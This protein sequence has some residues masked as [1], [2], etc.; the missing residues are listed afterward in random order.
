MRISITL[1][2]YDHGIIRQ[3]LDVV[4]CVVR[5]HQAPKHVSELQ[6]A[7]VFLD[8]FMDRFHHAK[9]EMFLFP[10][11]AEECPKVA[12]LLER[13]KEEHVTARRLLRSALKA[14]EEGDVERMEQEVRA[15]VDHMT[16]HIS[17]EEN[18][19]FP[20]VENTL[21]LETDAKLHA[22]YERFMVEK[23]GKSYYEVSEEFANDLQDRLLGPGYFTGIC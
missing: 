6:E 4:G 9:E 7:M 14:I 15:L 20:V 19:V 10:A 21:L 17:E 18:Q 13:L 22:Q 23:F 8:Q 12:D 1:L 11:A 3:V 2:Q 5:T 16:V